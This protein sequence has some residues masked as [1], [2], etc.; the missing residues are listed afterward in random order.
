MTPIEQAQ[1]YMHPT[2]WKG[3]SPKLIPVGGPLRPQR[4]LP[5]L[6]VN[7]PPYFPDEF[8]SVLRRK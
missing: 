4:L 2:A 8:F 6:L 1:R 3:N 7:M 5:G